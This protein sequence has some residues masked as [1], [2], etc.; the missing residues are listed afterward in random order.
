MSRGAIALLGAASIVSL[1]IGT[2]HEP[3][4]VWNAS[5][6]VPI[7]L[8]QLRQSPAAIGNLVLVHPPPQIA[9]LA[10]QRHYLPLHVP[11]IKRLA[12]RAGDRICARDH[13]VL[14]DGRY[15]AARRDFDSAHRPMPHWT[16][17]RRLH[18]DEIFL[19]NVEA[20]QSFDGRYFGPLKAATLGGVLIPLWTR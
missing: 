9:A 15:K 10:A 13:S 18:D 19:L 14:I 12:A 17:C 5:A 11:L 3:S 4:L 16:G 6:S 8:Y 7:G 20:P 1:W 2:S